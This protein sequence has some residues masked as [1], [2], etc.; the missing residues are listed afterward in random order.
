MEKLE[1][2]RKFKIKKGKDCQLIQKRRLAEMKALK[3]RTLQARMERNQR[4][5]KLEDLQVKKLV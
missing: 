4:S 1:K 2:V 5:R 3:A